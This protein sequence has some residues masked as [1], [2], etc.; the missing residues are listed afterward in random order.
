[1]NFQRIQGFTGGMVLL[2]AAILLAAT[3]AMGAGMTPKDVANLSSVAGAAIS[4]DGSAIAYVKSV[5]R[6]PYEDDD[7]PSWSELHVLRADGE[8]RPYITGK[9]SVRSVHWTPDG[10]GIAFVSKREGDEAPALYVIPVDGGEAQRVLEFSEGIGS[11]TFSPDGKRVAFLAREK[12]DDDEESLK[13]KGFK[14]VI[15]EEGQ[16]FTRVWVATLG[17]EGEDAE[18]KALELEGSASELHW[19]PVDSR[20]VVAL[21]PTPAVDDNLMLRRVHVVDADSGEV[22]AKIDNPG[23]LGNVAWSPDGKHLAILSGEDQHDSAAGRLMVVPAAG[24]ELRDL[25]PGLLGQVELVKWQDAETVVYI[26]S[27]GVTTSVYTLGVGEGAAP[28]KVVDAS[29]CWSGFDLAD[30]GALALVGGTPTHPGE[31]FRA[32]LNG[33]SSER[34]TTTNAWLQ[35]GDITRQEAITYKARD[36]ESIEAILQYPAGYEEG[37]RYPLIMHVHGGP[38]AHYCNGWMTSYG[39]PGQMAT[40]RGYF[41]VSPNYR[42][43][44]GRGVAFQKAHQGDFAGKEFD[45]LVDGIDHLVAEGKV[46]KDRVGITGGSYGGFASAWGATYYTE[47][48]KASVMFVGIS[49]QISKW[50]TSD[51][52]NEMYLVHQRMYPWDGWEKMLKRSPIYYAGQSRTA[53]LILGGLDDTRVDPGQSLELH[54]HLKVHGNVPVRLVQYPGEGHGNRNA[55]ARFDYSIRM[56]RWFDHFLKEDGK[57]LPAYEIDFKAELGLDEDE[58]D[59]EDGEKKG[60]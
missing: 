15:F 42:G 45:D 26:A 23:K 37:K 56:L 57:E 34:L 18:P 8:N 38:E 55:A 12:K 7:G 2:L 24:G 1:M 25:L 59:G 19:S 32:S 44:T 31:L 3:P 29:A 52:P 20:L 17:A 39:G 60:D 46:D 30:N 49:D 16:P 14:A 53:T 36:G 50:G 58:E 22:L 54:R 4:P 28:Q 13:K 11:Y 21:Q 47:R 5:Q 51:I 43:S 10:K 6:K 40:A 9:V 33:G 48:Y 35:E 41:V 27:E